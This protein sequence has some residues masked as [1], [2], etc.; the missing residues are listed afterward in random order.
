MHRILLFSCK[1]PHMPICRRILLVGILLT[2]FFSPLSAAETLLEAK[3]TKRVVVL[4]SVP[5]DFPAT[6]M[7]ERGIRETLLTSPIFHIQIFSEYLDL[8]RFRDLKQ[9]EALAE[10]LRRR[11]ADGA[12]ELVISVDVPAAN[13]LIEHAETIFPHIPIIVCSIPEVM[14]ERL[15]ASSLRQRTSGVL[16]P[17]SANRLVESALSLK[18][19]TKH[20]ALVSGAFENDT[21]RAIGLRKTIE[22]FGNGLQLIALEGLPFAELIE[23]V[24]TLPKDSII[25]F[26]TF[27][28]DGTGRSFVPREVLKVLSE[29]ADAPLFGLYESYL[30]YGIVGG[31]LI[32]LTLQG[33]KAAEMGLRVLTGTSPASLPF[34]D[35]LDTC[36]NAYDWRQLKRWRIHESS[37]PLGSTVSHREPSIWDLYKFYIIGFVSLLVLESMLIVAMV[38]NLQRRKRA[39]M[40]LR[41]SRQE[42]RTLA[43]RLISSQEEELR[44]LS[45]EFH[46][47]IG[48]RLAAVA[49]E[50]G[51]L[52]L[53]SPDIG[54]AVLEKIRYIKEQLIGLSRDVSAISRQIHPAI[55]QDLGLVRAINSQCVMFS[56]REGIAVEFEEQNIAD[57][58][59]KDTALCIY[60]V[61]Q[62]SLR[63]IAKHAQATRVEIFLQGRQGR[64]FLH[65]IDDG[66]GFVPQEARHTPGIGLAS[67]RERV[68]YVDGQF[69]IRSEPGMG[70]MI[71]VSVPIAKGNE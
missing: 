20:V 26:S 16:E 28:V 12:I 61:I 13:F 58:I 29:T 53:R 49:I 71:E 44:R 18:P 22:A 21:V 70:T 23:K 15:A 3:P 42:L 10:L 9:R 36:I 50:S 5:L 6:E 54:H 55:L 24:K 56:E 17:T 27:F 25:F 39:E 32:S 66:I 4:F 38:A 14:A 69:A 41:E 52:E 40:A 33:K 57:D 65:I 46:D 2:G 19:N 34:D 35:G 68:E 45:R 67:M 51:T 31:R 59:P 47:D 1:E 64:I 60:R 62:E 7:A 48:Q 8:S 43:G 11:Y 30:G 37:L 63:N